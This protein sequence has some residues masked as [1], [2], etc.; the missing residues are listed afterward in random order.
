MTHVTLQGSFLWN[1]TALNVITN[2]GSMKATHLRADAR[3]ADK[4]I[5]KAIFHILMKSD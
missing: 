4:S 1:V 2:F 3:L 5:D